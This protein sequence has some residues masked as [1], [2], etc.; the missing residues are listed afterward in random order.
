[1]K[2]SKTFAIAAVV[3]GTLLLGVGSPA[4]AATEARSA[5]TVR[6]QVVGRDLRP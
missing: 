4:S 3:A 2:P 1:M 5:S 6:W